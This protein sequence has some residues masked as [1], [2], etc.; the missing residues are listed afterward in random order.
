MKELE[1]RFNIYG[2]TFGIS[3]DKENT[4]RSQIHATGI[5]SSYTLETSLF[6]WKNSQNELVHFNEGDYEAIAENLARSIYLLEADPES[7]Q[8]QLG[9]SKE[10][11]VKQ[12]PLIMEIRE[13]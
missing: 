10:Y 8:S 2:C 11:I 5:K 12:L 1:P 6:G 13:S 3:K 7:T 9:M 4:L